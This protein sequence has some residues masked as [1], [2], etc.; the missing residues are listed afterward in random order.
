MSSRNPRQ[1]MLATNWKLGKR[2]IRSTQ[3]YPYLR[4]HADNE[5]CEG[6][7]LHDLSEL[8]QDFGLS[9]IWVRARDA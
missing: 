9:I 4:I 3:H 7:G 5:H 1:K 8:L 2:G 6:I